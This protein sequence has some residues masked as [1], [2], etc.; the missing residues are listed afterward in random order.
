MLTGSPPLHRRAKLN[1]HKSLDATHSRPTRSRSTHETV[2][3]E[4]TRRFGLVDRRIKLYRME[5]TS[6]IKSRQLRRFA[7]QSK[8]LTLFSNV[9]KILKIKDE[10]ESQRIKVAN[11]R[12]TSYMKLENN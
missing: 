6:L 11:R 2:A 1:L 5:R 10:K 4:L 3:S 8:T 9:S 7:I 12:Y